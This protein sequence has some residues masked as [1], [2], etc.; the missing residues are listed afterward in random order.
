MIVRDSGPPQRWSHRLGT[1]MFTVS[2]RWSTKSDAVPFVLLA[3]HRAAPGAVDTPFELTVESID[4]A[5]PGLR[6]GYEPHR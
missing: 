3:L 6:R 4:F 1:G 2:A 5:K